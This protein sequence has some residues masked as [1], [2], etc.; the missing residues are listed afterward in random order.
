MAAQSL[1]LAGA[2]V[3]RSLIFFSIATRV[4]AGYLRAQRRGR[5]LPAEEADAIWQAEHRKQSV[6]IAAAV[7]RLRGMLIKSG[8][9]LSARPDILPEPYIEALAGLQ[10]AVPPKPYR[11]IAGQIEKELGA[12][13]KALFATFD[14]VPVASASLAQVHHATLRDGREVAVKVLYPDIE[15]I[16][17]SDIF[18]LGVI[19][20][21]VGRIWPR[22][23]FRVIYREAKRL[24]PIELDLH[25]EAENLQ[26]IAS[27]LSHRNDLVVPALV[28]ALSRARV[29]TMQFVRGIKVNDIAGLRAAGLR[30]PAVAERVVDIFGDQV[31]EHGFFHGDPHPGNIFVLADGRI[32]LLDFGQALRLPEEVR[33]GFALLSR[34]AS[35]RDPAGMIRAIQM[36]GVALDENDMASY[37]R[38]ASQTLG[39]ATA[40]A[41]EPEDEG[42]AV[43]VRMAR[44]FRGISLDG[45]TGEA[46]FV[47]RVQGLL[48]GLRAHLG[49]PGNIITTWSKYADEVLANAAAD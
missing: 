42:A 40:P 8:Q 41:D 2:Q 31:L 4:A 6:R 24:V 13:V 46:L 20:N 49:A 43:N 28:P 18:S 39:L 47:F 37:V 36:V 44:G 3:R 10:D 14:R 7:T 32:A 16:V 25:H 1:R 11:L 21:I 5:G 17:R 35:A 15:G 33:R 26:H 45:M 29:L 48:R 19:V 9:Y 27:D 38:M 23:D 22:Y 30:P 12:P 34:S